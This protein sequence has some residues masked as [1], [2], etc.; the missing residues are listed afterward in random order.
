MLPTE[1]T[2][3]ALSVV[4]LVVHIGIQG[5]LVTKERGTAWNVGARDG[6]E[7]PLGPLAGRASRALTNYK[8][9]W[10]ALIALSL[11]L[12]VTSRTGGIGAAGAWLW[13]AA[14][15]VY[16]PLYLAGVPVL[17]TLVY[18]ASM[19]GLG[20]MLARLFIGA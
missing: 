4:L 10:P 6:A 11:A 17:R 16:L 12:A 13:L 20:M 14:R 8:E 19:A 1:L 2:V 15:L 18:L 5:A 3:L 9:T 7:A